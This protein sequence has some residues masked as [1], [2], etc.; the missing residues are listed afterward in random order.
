MV[1]YFAGSNDLHILHNKTTRNKVTFN[2]IFTAGGAYFERSYE[3]GLSHLLEH[4]L[5]ARTESLDQNDLN[6]YLFRQYLYTNAYTERD[7]ME[8]T[9]SGHRDA[10]PMMIDLLYEFSFQPYITNDVIKQEK[11]V[12]IQEI[13]DKQSLAGYRLNRM[14]LENIYR[15]DSFDYT[16]VLG[17]LE[18]VQH[19][20]RDTLT[21]LWHNMIERSHFIITATGPVEFD[22]LLSKFASL[23]FKK[24][25]TTL[26]INYSKKNY[27]RDFTYLPIHGSFNTE[28]TIV[29]LLFPLAVNLENKP[30]RAIIRE[31]ILN[32]PWGILYQTLRDKYGF[33]YDYRHAFDINNDLLGIEL[34]CNRANIDNIIEVV[35]QIFRSIESIVTSEKLVLIKNITLRKRALDA[36]E[37]DTITQFTLENL[38][39]HG[40]ILTSDEYVQRLHQVT[41]NDIHEYGDQMKNSLEH[42]RVVV[43]K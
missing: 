36:D 31:L 22:I 35:K 17:D 4:C 40:I 30:T 43:I 41:L 14:I 37:P 39:N 10:I 27:L 20:E 8:L 19:A 24:D 16:E 15:E 5:L 7:T 6:A 18:T 42:M 34:S 33:M 26:P 11:A 3:R 28:S 23:P 2:L 12:V 29:K 21:T 38:I 13:Y 32:K 9:I 1:S 25:N